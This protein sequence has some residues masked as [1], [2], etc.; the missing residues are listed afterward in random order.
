MDFIKGNLKKILFNGD[1]GY[2]VGLFKIKEAS[3]DAIDFVN[4]TVTFTGYFHELNE[5]DTYVLHGKF[6]LMEV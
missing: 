6:I 1:N 2:L 5:M 4:Q 3:D